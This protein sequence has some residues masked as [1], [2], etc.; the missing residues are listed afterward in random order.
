LLEDFERKTGVPIL[1]NTS[2]NV[3]GQPMVCTPEEAIETFLGTEIDDLV[4]GP[5]LVSKE[6]A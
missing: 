2:F 5:C 6:R 1:L 3:R 4:V